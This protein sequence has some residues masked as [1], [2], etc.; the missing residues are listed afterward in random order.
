MNLQ[1]I[2]A[3]DVGGPDGPGDYTEEIVRYF[4][5]PDDS[6]FPDLS[7]LPVVDDHEKRLRQ[8]AEKV[9]WS[10]DRLYMHSWHGSCGTV[11]CIG[12]WAIHLA[13]EEGKLLEEINGSEAAAYMLLGSEAYGHFW[14]E[15]WDAINWLREVLVRPLS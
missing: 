13:G 4:D 3:Q 1:E 12:G 10:P 14:D 7:S 5:S 8:V 11:H 15:R 9:L 6:D 2:L